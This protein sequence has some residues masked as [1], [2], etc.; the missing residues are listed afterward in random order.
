M[1]KKQT[2]RLA[3]FLLGRRTL[4]IALFQALLVLS[5]LILSWLLR[6]DFSLPDRPLLL[7]AAAI[8]ILIRLGVFAWF[9]LFRGWWRYTGVSDVVDIVKAVA[10]GSLLFWGLLRYL[11]EV[12]SFP[13]SVYI[14]EAILTAGALASVR[15]FSR[16]L[17]ES[18]REDLKTSRKVVLIGAGH[19]A[20]T[21]IREIKG[22]GSG[23][24]PVA[25]VDDDRSKLGIKLNG[26]PVVGTVDQLPHLAEQV[27]VDEVLIA[28]PSATGAQMRKFV[29]ICERARVK[30]KTVPSLCEIIAGKVS[31][32]E[33]RDVDLEDLLGREPIRV[34]LEAVRK[35]IKGRGVIVTGAAGS[36]GSELCRQILDYG[37]RK[38]ICV[39]Q[40]ET[41]VFYLR[42]ELSSHQ[43]GAQV[44]FCVADVRDR[45]AMLRIWKEYAPQH[46]FHAAAY[47][48]VPIMESNV[49]EAV[50]N[51]V[52]ALLDLLEVAED[53][54]C[55]SF[56]LIS[57]D[58]A[59]NPTSVMGATKRIGELILSSRPANG[60][61]CTSVRFGNVLG[62]SGSVVPVLQEQLRK[63]QPLTVTHPDIKRFFMTTHEAV[64]LVLQAFAI[65]DH[66]DT[67]VL[68][69]GEPI[70][71]MDLAKNLIRLSGKS[72]DEVPINITGLREGEKLHEELFYS[73]ERMQPTPHQKIKRAQTASN[74]WSL[75]R[76]QLERLRTSMS[77]NGS[78]SI[79]A[80]LKE[81][82]PEFACPQSSVP[83]SRE[84]SKD[85]EAAAFHEAAA[86]D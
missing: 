46:L 20:Q 35:R 5:A 7:S 55:E 18:M 34:D 57:S 16:V 44:I 52:F 49:H 31:V 70:R 17:S 67:L 45:K 74:G 22:A 81:I 72:E 36:I 71:I 43:N 6:F 62:S 56:V 69:M 4:F 11:L 19:A 53:A 9:N 63:N 48:H 1:V 2:P 24:I 3:L 61:R 33:V 84:E 10:V 78:E 59:V 14:L 60:M 39:D 29:E 26:V 75:L 8:L 85:S 41:G 47:K 28:V 42:Q 80:Q 37:P 77:Q 25:C 58:K 30:F 32:N 86:S 79:R 21:V 51:N 83:E 12:S 65:G 50:S 64:A 54:G 66:G 38:L 27:G 73:D 82:V 13:R 23:Y 15:L 40:S 76:Q 68:D